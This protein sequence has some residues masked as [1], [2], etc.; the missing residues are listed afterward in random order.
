MIKAEISTPL[1][2]IINQSISS[3]IFPDSLKIAKVKPLFKK[4]IM[5]DPG[6]FRPISILPALSKIFEKIILNQLLEYFNQNSLLYKSQY[7]FRKGFSTEL[8]VLEFVDR[9][10]TEMDRGNVPI[11]VFLDL[12]KAFDCID[13]NI[14]IDKFEYYG[15]RGIAMNLIKNYLT[16]RQQ[17]TQFNELT[18]NHQP[19]SIGVPQGSNLGP[20][21]F[22]VYI[23]DLEM[24]SDVFK[25][26][27][28]ADDSTLLTTLNTGISSLNEGAINN[29][30]KNVQNWFNANKLSTNAS[31]TKMMIFH[32][33]K[34]KVDLPNILMNGVPLENVDNFTYLGIT[35]NK[36]LSWK[37]HAEKIA[38]K[39]SKV[40][41]ILAKLKSLVPTKILLSI[42]NSL[43]ACHLSYGILLWGKQIEQITK[44]QKKSMRLI[45]DAKYN[46][47][48]DPIFK[49]LKIQKIADIRKMQEIIFFSKFVKKCLPSY[50]G[51]NYIEISETSTRQVLLHYPRFWHEYF[52]HN[53]R[54]S[55]AE[56]VNNTSPD[57]IKKCFTHSLSSLKTNIKLKQ[58][59]KY[60]SEC[61]ITGCFV[62][63]RH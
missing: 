56:T 25:I 17:Y 34:K 29:E 52:R 39:I 62:C 45:V 4:G 23:N 61:N 60:E 22:L 51:E 41:G 28:Y 38:N 7:G 8:A 6:N 24:S 53:L 33:P 54:F 16:N 14:L 36:H 26:I 12:S 55:I 18:S 15:V 35:L 2:K 27:N 58:I 30:L 50:F 48:T 43:I 5:T 11:S 31:K 49:K 47:H 20:F 46:S 21:L 63:G 42:Y 3:G 19:I 1:V 37:P 59:D 13:H 32:P 9:V 44:L 10:Y 40:N 57:L